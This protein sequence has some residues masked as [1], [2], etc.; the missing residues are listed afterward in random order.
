VIDFVLDQ[1]KLIRKE[2]QHKIYYLVVVR[3]V[4]MAVMVDIP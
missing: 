1:D 2:Y 4:D 3:I